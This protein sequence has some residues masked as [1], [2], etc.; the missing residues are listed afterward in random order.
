MPIR[1]RLAVLCVL[2]LALSACA[3]TTKERAYQIAFQDR[4]ANVYATYPRDLTRSQAEARGRVIYMV[5]ST[6]RP[7]PCD[8]TRDDCYA[9]LAN[10]E[11]RISSLGTP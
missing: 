5:E 11:D 3:A 4:M 9:K 1:H 10:M 6:K 8:G 2:P 7:V